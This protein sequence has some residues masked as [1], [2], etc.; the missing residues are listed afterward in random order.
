M[1]LPLSYFLFSFY[2]IGL[3]KNEEKLNSLNDFFSIVACH[4]TKMTFSDVEKLFL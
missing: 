1:L 3:K 2:K 4:V